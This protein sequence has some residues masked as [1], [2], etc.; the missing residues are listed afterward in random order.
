M[1]NRGRWEAVERSMSVVGSRLRMIELIFDLRICKSLESSIHVFMSLI[2]KHVEAF[3]I[4]AQ[5]LI[6]VSLHALIP[7]KCNLK[8]IPSFFGGGGIENIMLVTF[9][10]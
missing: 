9:T 6:S 5:R 1:A 10:H 8:T 3:G 4:I 7:K 2:V